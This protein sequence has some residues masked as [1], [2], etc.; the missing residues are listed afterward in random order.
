MIIRGPLF[1]SS[2]VF[3]Q[4]ITK[5]EVR[6]VCMKATLKKATSVDEIRTEMLKIDEIVNT[7]YEFF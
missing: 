2:E 4:Y 6:G 7:L 1:Q 3:K 5:E